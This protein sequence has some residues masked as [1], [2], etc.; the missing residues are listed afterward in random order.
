MAWNVRTSRQ[1]SA[2]LEIFKFPP[3][4][5]GFASIVLDATA[6]APDEDGLREL[7]AGTLLSKNSN[8]QYERFTGAGAANEV[9][10]LDLTGVT[11]GDVIITVDVN[12]DVQS[13]DP[14]AFDS[15]TG[16]WDAAIEAL[17]NVVAVT[18]TQVTAPAAGVT[19]GEFTVAFT[20]PANQD[21]TVTVDDS[22]ATGDAVVGTTTEG[23]IAQAVRGVLAHGVKFVDGT[24][25]SDQPA[26]MAFHS[27]VFRADRIIDFGTHGAAARAAL[28]TCRFD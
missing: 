21:V 7:K 11:D 4:E 18:T 2:D 5:Q 23:D 24:S 25:K 22:G 9:T 8:N 26:A 13:T 16:A 19:G 17:S 27:E 15:A 12:G 28:P 10:V 6:V 14:V 3:N 1:T 20:N